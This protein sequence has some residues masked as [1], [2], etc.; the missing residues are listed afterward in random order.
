MLDGEGNVKACEKVC[1]KLRSVKE[2]Y[3]EV[4]NTLF[5]CIFEIDEAEYNH[6]PR[7]LL[8]CFT[9]SKLSPYLLCIYIQWKFYIGTHHM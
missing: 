7:L 2:I 5:I 1:L 9:Q 8:I 4:F 3:C 6:D